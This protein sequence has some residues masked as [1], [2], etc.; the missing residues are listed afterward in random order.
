MT[1]RRCRN[2]HR[3]DGL[4]RAQVIE[5][6][7]KAFDWPRAKVLSWYEKENPRLKKARPSEL[8]D[9]GQSE[10]VE[11]FLNLK[12]QERLANIRRSEKKD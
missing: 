9:R 1:Y 8:V 6:A 10:I 7:I 5:L 2:P 12:N 11:E 3:T 4:T